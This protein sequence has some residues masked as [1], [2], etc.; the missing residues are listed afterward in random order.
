[1][2]DPASIGGIV[3]TGLSTALNAS[4]QSKVQAARDDAMAAERQRQTLLD[5]E[6]Y[7]VNNESRNTYKDV[8][9]KEGKRSKALSEYFTAQKVEAPKESLLPT[10]ASNVTVQEEGKQRAQAADF[11]KRTGDAL[12]QLR[13]F[14]D[15]MADNSLNQAQGA[16]QVGQIAGYKRGSSDVLSYELDDANRAGDGLKLFGDI[17]SGVGG[18]AL[19]KGL[20]GPAATT[21]KPNSTLGAVIGANPAG[22]VVTP[23]IPAPRDRLVNSMSPTLYG[24]IL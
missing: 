21:F 20:S 9:K 2:C 17:V 24:K 14:G 18:L 1:M 15:L 8:D 11:T 16:M 12:G 23:T 22:T 5:R 13:S 10:S 19:S 3:L 6:A 4:A 7:A